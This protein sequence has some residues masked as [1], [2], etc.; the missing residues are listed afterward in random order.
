[1]P[2]L[3]ETPIGPELGLEPQR[4]ELYEQIVLPTT[5]ESPVSTDDYRTGSE[6]GGVG[7]LVQ[8]SPHVPTAAE[9][10]S[11]IYMIDPAD[12]GLQTDSVAA[13]ELEG[14]FR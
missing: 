5:S 13:P 8:P 9:R 6:F 2:N 14:D 1:M 10:L 3:P 12:D 11:M 7:G 4:P